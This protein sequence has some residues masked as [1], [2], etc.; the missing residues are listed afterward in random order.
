M[1]RLQYGKIAKPQAGSCDLFVRYFKSRPDIGFR[2]L[3]LDIAF[4]PR[5]PFKPWEP[6][7]LK[8]GFVAVVLFLL[9]ACAWLGY[10]SL[11]G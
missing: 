8:K 11:A 6:R 5:N 10:F 7:K 1:A 9:I 2:K 4:E 3:L